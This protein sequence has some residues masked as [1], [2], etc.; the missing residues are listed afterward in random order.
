MSNIEV[1]FES[2]KKLHPEGFFAPELVRMILDCPGQELGSHSFSHY[3]ACKAGQI[4]DQWRADLRAAK[5]IAFE[6]LGVIPRSLVF[7]RN[8]YSDEV[9]QIAGEE[10]FSAVRTNPKDWFWRDVE[11][12]SI[13]KKIFRTGDTLVNLGIKT[14]YHA[15]TFCRE[16]ALLPASRLLRPFRTG[17]LFNMKRTN[18]IKD[19][20]KVALKN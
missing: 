20:L 6:K 2:Q 14:S 13:L 16:M 19:E 17:S 7:P 18:K 1:K 11:Q 15:P 8:Q 12:E 5:R 9:I 10:G 3:Y 4:P